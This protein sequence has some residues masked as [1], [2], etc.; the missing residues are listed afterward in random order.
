MYT[1]KWVENE[2]QANYFCLSLANQLSR[3]D[4]NG[5]NKSSPIL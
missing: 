1:Q 2:R 5:K 4:T 3:V